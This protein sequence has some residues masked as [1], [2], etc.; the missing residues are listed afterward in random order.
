MKLQ[1]EFH[2]DLLNDSRFVKTVQFDGQF[3]QSDEGNE[4]DSTKLLKSKRAFKKLLTN[5]VAICIFFP[6]LFAKFP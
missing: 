4:G 3:F 5:N 2:S 6:Q 1:H